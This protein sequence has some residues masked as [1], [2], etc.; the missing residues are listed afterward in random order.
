M[1]WQV[2]DDP[3]CVDRPSDVRASR[4][5]L[6]FGHIYVDEEPSSAHSLG[7]S[8]AKHLR[9]GYEDAGHI[10]ELE[11]LIDDYNPQQSSLDVARY[12]ASLDGSGMR[13][14]TITFE[15]ELVPAAERLLRFTRRR[16]ARSYIQYFEKKGKMPC[17]VLVAAWY[18]RRLERLGGLCDRPVSD[19]QIVNVLEERF[20]ESEIAALDLLAASWACDHTASISTLFV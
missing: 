3:A 20:R 18:L 15:S 7:V 5:S 13:P 11:L 2:Q 9:T 16:V 12:V 19:A 10:V 4:V 17:S 1:S 14:T 8:L 6:E